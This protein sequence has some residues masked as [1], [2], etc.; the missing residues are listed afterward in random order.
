MQDP[1]HL[2]NDFVEKW[3]SGYDLVYGTRDTRNEF[4]IIKLIRRLFYNIIFHSSNGKVPKN[5][6]DFQ[7]VDK[8]ILKEMSNI[9]DKTP[10]VRTLAFIKTDNHIGISYKW[11]KRKHGKSRE[12]LK[13]LMDTGINGFISVTNAPFRLVLYS[14]IIISL[15]SILYAIVSII[16][17]LFFRLPDIPKGIP[18]IIVSLFFLSGIQLFV[19]GYI[20]EYIAS[21]NNQVRDKNNV[22]VRE[23]LNF[24][25]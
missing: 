17:T 5:I 15:M 4:I 6:S 1:P 21:I 8:R 24:D 10:F 7:L 9:D 11:G 2:I 16:L 18:T 25:K 3:E 13:D 12:F 19:L 23:T 20:G 22:N 14:G